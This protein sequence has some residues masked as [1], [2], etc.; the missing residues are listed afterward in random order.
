MRDNPRTTGRLARR[1]RAAL[2]AAVACASESARSALAGKR[3]KIAHLCAITCTLAISGCAGSAPQ[4]DSR[5]EPNRPGAASLSGPETP[6]CHIARALLVSPPAPDCGFSRSD[7]KTVDPDQWARLKLEFERKCFQ[8]AEKTVRERLRLLQAA[9]NR[10][11]V[12]QASRW[13]KS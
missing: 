5:S 7:L 13:A 1:I 9:A 8:H 4:P 10:C 2:D 11:G 12:E 6:K 3:R